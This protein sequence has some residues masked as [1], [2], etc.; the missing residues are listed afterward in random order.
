MMGSFVEAS[1]AANAYRGEL[2]RL[3]QVHLILLAVQRTA[4]A[5]EGKIVVYSDCL[6]ALGWMSLLPRIPTCC[7]HSDILKNILVNC[8]DFTFQQKF[9]HVKAHQDD[10]VDFHL[11]DWPAQLNCIVDAS[12]K[13]E[14]LN[15]DVMALPW[16]Q[17][18]P[19]EPIYCFVGK[20]KMTSNTRPLLRFWAYKQIARDVFACCKIFD[21][22]LFK[23]V[24]WSYVSAALEEVPR[25]FQLWVCKQVMGI[26]A[27][28][29]LQAKWTEGLSDKCPS[30]CM[31]KEMCGHIL[32]CDEVGRVE[33]LMQTIGFLEKWLL[34]SETYPELANGLVEFA[35]SQGMKSLEE[36]C[37]HIPQLH[38]MAAAQDR[39]GW[40]R[41]M[42]GMICTQVVE[43]QYTYQ[44]L[45][46]TNFTLKQRGRRKYSER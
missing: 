29:G 24:A 36:I 26:A 40:C 6:G 39:I 3:M 42:A 35:H 13:Q 16:Q 15:T 32:H 33:V 21:A 10:L 30:C 45:C 22:E 25:I 17:C 12:A 27:T 38:R 34:E 19:K 41:F 8:G 37:R 23:L 2:L 28:N 31:V 1:S 7:R 14:I 4:P 11:L 44:R 9:C 43:I 46:G 18:F 20:E 5:L